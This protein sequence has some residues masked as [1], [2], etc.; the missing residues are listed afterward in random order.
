MDRSMEIDRS[1]EPNRPLDRSM[2]EP[3]TD[4]ASTEQ[5]STEY[6]IYLALEERPPGASGWYPVC[7]RAAQL[8]GWTEQQA[9][10]GFDQLE[11]MTDLDFI[12]DLLETAA[13]LDQAAA[14]AGIDPSDL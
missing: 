9:R 13:E 12:A 1:M 6:R 14:E 8:I 7:N 2:E 10:D 3:M 11:A 4:Q 5:E